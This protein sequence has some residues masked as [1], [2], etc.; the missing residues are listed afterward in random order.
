[1]IVLIAVL[2]L[3]GPE[4]TGSQSKYKV[5]SDVNLTCI[6]AKSKPAAILKWYIFIL[7]I[8]VQ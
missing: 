2:P 7:I 5:G 1:M 6:S 3:G 4:I 8:L